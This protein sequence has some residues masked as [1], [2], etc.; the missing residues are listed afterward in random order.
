MIDSDDLYDYLRHLI[1]EYLLTDQICIE[2]MPNWSNSLLIL[3]FNNTPFYSIQDNSI[4][5]HSISL[6]NTQFHSIPLN[7][8]QFHSIPL[9]SNQFNHRLILYLFNVFIEFPWHFLGLIQLLMNWM[10]VKIGVGIGSG[11]L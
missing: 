1:T 5:L 9:N 7:S 3:L 8:T 10:N 11:R 2:F 4:Q 6:N